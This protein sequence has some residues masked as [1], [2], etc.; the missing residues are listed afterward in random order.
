MRRLLHLYPGEGHTRRALLERKREWLTEQRV[1]LVL[2]DD[3]IAA[4]DQALYA[5]TVLLPPSQA[6][7]T[8]LETLLKA[9]ALAHCD[10]VLLQSEAALPAGALF[11]AA[12]A[13]PGPTPAAVL[14]CFDKSATRAAL[15]VAGVT[16]PEF[17]IARDAAD[18][19]RFG[20]AYGWPLM[21]K[22]FA[23]T[24]ARLV[25]K[26]D[27]PSEVDAAVASLRADL[28]RSLDV[29]RLADFARAAGLPLPHD[30][31]SHFLC[32]R[33][34]PGAPF[35]CDGF[36]VAG[37]ARTFGVIEQVLTAPPRFYLEGYLLPA[38]LPTAS[39]ARIESTSTRA[40][41]ALGLDRTGFSI[42][43]RD[44]GEVARVIEVNG[45]LGEDSGLWQLFARVAGR[46][47]FEL[48][49]AI[50]IGEAP[51]FDAAQAAGNVHSD[52]HSDDRSDAAALRHAL[53]FACRFEE[54]RVIAVPNFAQIA[55]AIARAPPAA[56]SAAGLCVVLGEEM[57]A[58]PHPETFP[59][60]AWALASAPGSSRAAYSIA[61]A[62]ACS[63]RVEVAPPRLRSSA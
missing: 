21:L 15:A 20:E 10:G 53:A 32:E 55:A 58:P 51:S 49:V 13:L 48:A 52:D 6:V 31:R 19:R 38:D 59:H 2:G 63:L 27:S 7:G 39:R 9:P 36:I 30:P 23:S 12:R 62:L 33:V 24:M 25:T 50:A 8:T 42:E 37:R 4:E 1:E 3:W 41:E 26:V 22:A 11:A 60:L 44:N 57:H 56:L 16:Q 14:A 34:A 28:P 61:R 47:P 29:A 45:R 5:D 17:A 18:A 40:A 43:L 46:D 35:E 54:G